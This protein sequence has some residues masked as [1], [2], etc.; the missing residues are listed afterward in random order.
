[1]L[2]W[3]GRSQKY[4]Y[5]YIAGTGTPE[6]ALIIGGTCAGDGKPGTLVFTTAKAHSAGYTISSATSGI[7]GSFNS[8]ARLVHRWKKRC[9]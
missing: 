9:L 2:R 7:A 4:Y 8:S 6:A 1:M 5:V 3:R